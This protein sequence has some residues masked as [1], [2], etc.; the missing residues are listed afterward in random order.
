MINFSIA[1]DGL[2]T[3]EYSGIHLH[4]SY[5]PSKESEKFFRTNNLGKFRTFIL[6]EPCL[7]YL[8]SEIKKNIPDAKII[9]LHVSDEFKGKEKDASDLSWQPSDVIPVKEFLGKSLN[10]LDLEQLTLID[11]PPAARMFNAETSELKNIVSQHLRELHGNITTVSGFGRRLV[12]NFLPNYRNL[13]KII[14]PL[15]TDSPVFI[16]GSGPGLSDSLSFLSRNRDRMILTALPS[17]VDYLIYHGLIPDIIVTTDPGYY[18]GLHLRRTENIPLASPLT[19]NIAS[20]RIHSSIIP[21]NQHSFIENNIFDN[22]D[23]FLSL[24]ANGTVA[25]TAL[26]FSSAITSGPVLISGLDFSFIDILSHSRPHSFDTLL[27]SSSSK[28]NNL[29]NIYFSRNVPASYPA[30]GG[31]RRTNKPLTTYRGWFEQN[32]RSFSGRFFFLNYFDR[33]PGHFKS[34]SEIE[35]EALLSHPPEI[36]FAIADNLPEKDRIHKISRFIDSELSELYSTARLFEKRDNFDYRLMTTLFSSAAAQLFLPNLLEIKRL[37]YTDDTET[38]FNKADSVIEQS[39]NFIEK[40]R[41][42]AE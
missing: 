22:R 31:R 2:L 14:F 27:E 35:A 36:E 4:S 19:A 11:W 41:I 8:S 26:Y 1:K 10:E 5:S 7:N 23:S 29:E 17:S 25:G 20:N 42:Y 32:S 39:I 38:V 34:I 28:T 3:A 13:D 40:L 24:P 21:L 12:R 18:A 33:A 16:A 9:T 37:L 30:G 6:I 15:K